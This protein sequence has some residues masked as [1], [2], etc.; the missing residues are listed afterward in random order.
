MNSSPDSPIRTWREYLH[1]KFGDSD[2]FEIRGK[3]PPEAPVAVIEV[4]AKSNGTVICFAGVL[5]NLDC[6]S[7]LQ[8]YNRVS[9]GFTGEHDQF[10]D[11]GRFTPANVRYVEQEL[12][13]PL[14]DG[15]RSEDFY[16]LQRHFK[17]KV[18]LTR[19][20]RRAFHYYPNTFGCVFFPLHWLLDLLVSAGIIGTKD[21]VT[22]APVQ[23]PMDSAE[24]AT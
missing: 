16:L 21:T 11:Q 14:T 13:T 2:L 20:S 17:S 19:G 8:Y 23:P 18:Y 24:P 15:W 4:T 9:R 6:L 10:E 5:D 3:L 22:I 12:A 7:D 1:G